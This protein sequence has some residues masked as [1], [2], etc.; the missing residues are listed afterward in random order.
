MELR[1]V[2]LFVRGVHAV[3]VE[4]KADHD[5]IHPQYPFEIR[6]N[7]DRAAFPDSDGLLAPFGGK[8]FAGSRKRRTVERKLGCR[9]Q[10]EVL[11]IGVR[12]RGQALSHERTEGVTN[13]FRILLADEAKRDFRGRMGWNDRLCSFSGIAPHHAV[14]L[15]GGPGG[16]LLDPHAVALAR[17]HLE[18]DRSEAIL[19]FE[20]KGGKVFFDL[21]RQVMNARIETWNDHASILIVHVRQNT[22]EHAKGIL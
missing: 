10:A 5:R 20:V 15:R 19:R 7:G 9:S 17:G 6:D 4:R 8:R 2:V 22:R 11:E 16:T 12:V 21:W 1:Q 3:I 18:P 13:L 14:D